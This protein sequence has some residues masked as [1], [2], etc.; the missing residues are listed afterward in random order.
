MWPLQVG[1]AGARGSVASGRRGVAGVGRRREGPGA[2]R[3]GRRGAAAS[4]GRGL[5]RGSGLRGGV[6]RLAPERGG[7]WARW[8]SPAA[9]TSGRGTPAWAPAVRR[10]RVCAGVP[11]SAGET[12]KLPWKGLPGSGRLACRDRENNLDDA[13][14]TPFRESS[15]RPL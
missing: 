12:C 15:L 3:G 1:G 10:S 5:A 8:E 7:R 9:G 2:A 14:W 4:C 13:A 6:S 11:T